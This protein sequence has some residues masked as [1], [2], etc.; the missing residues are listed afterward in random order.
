M[1]HVNITWITEDWLNMHVSIQAGFSSKRSLLLSAISDICL[2]SL[3][4]SLCLIPTSSKFLTARHTTCHRGK[5]KGKDCFML[6][7]AFDITSLGLSAVQVDKTTLWNTCPANV[8]LTV[9]DTNRWSTRHVAP[10]AR[11]PKPLSQQLLSGVQGT[12]RVKRKVAMVP[13]QRA[14]GEAAGAPQTPTQGS[15]TAAGRLEI[16]RGTTARWPMWAEFLISM[17]LKAFWDL[18]KR[19]YGTQL[20]DGG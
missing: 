4:F 13:R 1:H 14:K 17:L 7:F 8:Q 16:N 19:K 5:G 11:P 10:S 2:K 18:G 3:P 12:L 15:H 9:M 6:H 20:K